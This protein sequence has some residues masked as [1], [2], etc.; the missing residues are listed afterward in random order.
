MAPSRPMLRQ[1]YRLSDLR[2]ELSVSSVPDNPRSMHTLFAILIN[3]IDRRADV[4][5]SIKPEIL[6]GLAQAWLYFA[7][8]Q[9]GVDVIVEQERHGISTSIEDPDDDRPASSM[10]YSSANDCIF[11]ERLRDRVDGH[12]PLDVFHRDMRRLDDLRHQYAYP[13]LNTAEGNEAEELR[14]KYDLEHREWWQRQY[15]SEKVGTTD[16]TT[17]SPSTASS[18]SR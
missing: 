10:P 6:E 1:E 14:E 3:D 4:H 16:G 5:Q 7:E 13:G 15:L 12:V 18:A 17:A 8:N 11:D 9:E 2:N